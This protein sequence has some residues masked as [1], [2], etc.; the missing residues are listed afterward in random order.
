MSG[1][2]V[3]DFEDSLIA[4]QIFINTKNYIQENI[5][6]LI[7]IDKHFIGNETTSISTLKNKFLHGNENVTKLYIDQLQIHQ[8]QSEMNNF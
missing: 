5:D 4:I 1:T 8:Q 2:S 7:N 3:D 6:R